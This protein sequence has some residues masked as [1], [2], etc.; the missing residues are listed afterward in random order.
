MKFKTFTGCVFP[1]LRLLVGS[2]I[3]FP[4]VRLPFFVVL[5]MV[6]SGEERPDEEHTKAPGPT[7][8]SLSPSFPFSL[9]L[10]ILRSA[11]AA[12]ALAGN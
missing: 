1:F 8:P 12:A 6:L 11:V 7:R 10:E 3:L 4:S 9:S 2:L 5:F